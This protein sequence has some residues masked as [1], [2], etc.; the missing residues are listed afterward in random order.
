LLLPLRDLTGSPT[1]AAQVLAPVPGPNLREGEAVVDES[2]LPSDDSEG[3]EPK[4][5]AWGKA[6]DAYIGRLV[7]SW[8]ALRQVGDFDFRFSDNTDMKLTLRAPL[9][10]PGAVLVVRTAF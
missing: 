7:S 2:N 4:P 10:N 6:V 9:D 8:E 3:I 5:A 1:L